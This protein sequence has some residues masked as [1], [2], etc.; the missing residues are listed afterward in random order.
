[1]TEEFLVDDT[2]VE[3]TPE[4]VELVSGGRGAQIDPNG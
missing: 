2:L 3:V 4:L 1:M